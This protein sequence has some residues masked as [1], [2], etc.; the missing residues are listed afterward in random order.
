[1]T[2]TIASTPPT[3]ANAGPPESP[4]HVCDGDG[5]NVS[6]V[7]VSD[8]SAVMPARFC[9]GEVS[10]AAVSPKPT[11]RSAVPTAEAS[12]G[13]PG[14]GHGVAPAG[15]SSASSAIATSLASVP[16]SN[17]GWR[18]TSAIG[19]V[20]PPSPGA[21]P[22]YA[23]GIAPS[24]TQCAAVKSTRGATSVAVHT[25]VDA[26]NRATTPGSPSSAVPLVM[27][28]ARAAPGSDGEQADRAATTSTAA[29][30]RRTTA[31]TRRAR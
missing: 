27:A 14:K 16:A 21:L 29:P 28:P 24:G 15:A 7:A 18:R 2:P 5:A 12:S 4:S 1:M 23:V 10:P 9:G 8:A 13:A 30:A 6:S 19:T 3:V 22:K 25:S 11:S 26:C 20:G 31:S 17:A